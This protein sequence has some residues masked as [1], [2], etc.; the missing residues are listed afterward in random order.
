MLCKAGSG[1]PGGSLSSADIL[2]TL[3]FYKMKFD[4]KNPKLKE[5]DRFILSKGHACPALYSVLAELG[6]FPKEEL[7]NLRKISCLLQGHPSIK[8]P[9][10][11]ANTGSLGQGLSIANGIA[12]ACRLDK[13]KNKVYVLLGDGELQEGQVWEAAMTSAHYNLDNLVAIIDHNGLQI[14]GF[15]K[16]IKNVEPLKEKWEAFGWYVIE[17][18][19]HDFE[20]II[21]A[22]DK[23]DEIKK[24]VMIIANTVKGKGVDFMENKCEWHGKTPNKEEFDRALCNLN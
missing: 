21:N 8:I 1:H 11:E 18:N 13:L 4:S 9:G 7:N 24:P 22:L 15:V 19:G 3:Y 20:E 10:I 14:D 17:I 16:D 6:F 5:R 23:A 2:T 12:L